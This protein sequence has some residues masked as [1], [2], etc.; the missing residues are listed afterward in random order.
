MHYFVTNFIIMKKKSAP[1]KKTAKK[2]GTR[3]RRSVKR[4]IPDQTPKYLLMVPAPQ[5]LQQFL[6]HNADL[7]NLT[8]LERRCK[9][10][11]GTLRHIRTGT[12]PA[13]WPIYEAVRNNVLGDLLGLALI[14]QNYGR[15]FIERPMT[16]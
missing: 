12:R 16:K 1:K 4:L 3:I 7:F 9:L 5:A 2:K 6:K 13:T 10:P 14:L 8:E 11:N 15:E